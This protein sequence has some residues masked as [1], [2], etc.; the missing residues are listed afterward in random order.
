[1]ALVLLLGLPSA[2]GLP[3]HRLVESAGW[4]R[5]M[6]GPASCFLYTRN[7]ASCSVSRVTCSDSISSSISLSN[8]RALYLPSGSCAANLASTSESGSGGATPLFCLARRVCDG[9]GRLAPRARARRSACRRAGGFESGVGRAS[10]RTART[11]ALLRGVARLL[12]VDPFQGC[13][14]L[15]AECTAPT[16]LKV[17]RPGPPKCSHLTSCVRHVQTVAA[18]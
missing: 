16:A 8:A 17:F 12:L 4:P 13:K 14:W 11:A 10:V 1:M 15:L 3:Y 18:R 9:E 2:E 7:R 5:G 6:A